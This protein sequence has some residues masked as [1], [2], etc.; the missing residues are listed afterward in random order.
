MPPRPHASGR[1]RCDSCIARKNTRCSR[2][3]PKCTAC[4]NNDRECVYTVNGQ[5]I[6]P[7]PPPSSYLSDAPPL[8]PVPLKRPAGIR[9]QRDT[10]T[11]LFDDGDSDQGPARPNRGAAH[12]NDNGDDHERRKRALTSPKPNNPTQRLEYLQLLEAQ[13]KRIRE[14]IRMGKALSNQAQNAGDPSQARPRVAGER[15]VATYGLD[16]GLEEGARTDKGKNREYLHPAHHLS[17]RNTAQGLVYPR[18]SA[19]PLSHP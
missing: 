13:A 6:P 4:A 14:E 8:H 10:P 15:G 9:Y 5:A 7:P 16:C 17:S 3:L 19:V 1:P 11:A 12:A 2:D 18:S